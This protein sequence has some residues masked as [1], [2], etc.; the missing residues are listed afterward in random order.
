[1]EFVTV[2]SW[3]YVIAMTE[4]PDFQRWGDSVESLAE[5]DA[6]LM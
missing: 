1:M 6:M 5:D 4:P 2:T 3:R